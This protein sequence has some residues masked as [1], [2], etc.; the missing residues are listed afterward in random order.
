MTTSKNNAFSYVLAAIS[1]TLII[2]YN[3]PGYWSFTDSEENIN[4]SYYNFHYS[5]VFFC[6]IINLIN[7]FVQAHGCNKVFSIISAI[8]GFL[9]IVNGH[10]F[11]SIYRLEWVE[12]DYG[13][14]SITFYL[15]FFLL[16]VQ[17]ILPAILLI[18]ENA[19]KE[20]GTKIA[21]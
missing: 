9:G 15:I 20:S 6:Y 11:F 17:L 2:C 12:N 14:Y 1:L 13:H 10:M 19:K 18:I 5:L 16:L 4:F 7:I 8:V 21:V 3:L